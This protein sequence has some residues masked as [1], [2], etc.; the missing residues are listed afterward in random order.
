MADDAQLTARRARLGRAAYLP[1]SFTLLLGGCANL[2]P[3]QGMGPIQ[4]M[5]LSVADA[6]LIKVKSEE[7]AAEVKDRVSALLRKPLTL[8]SAVQIALLNNRGLQAAYNGLGITEAQLAKETL[9]PNPSFSYALLAASNDL[10]IE[11]QVAINVPAIL[12]LP[13]RTDIARLEF[14]AAQFRAMNETLKAAAETRRAFIRAVAANET[15]TFLEKSQLSAEAAS[16]LAKKLGQTGA[17]NKLDQAREHAFYAELSAQ[18][19]SARLRQAA[20]REKLTRLLGLWGSDIGYRLPGQ[21]KPLPGKP[22][23]LETAER[24]AVANRVDLEMLRLELQA[25]AKALGLTEATRFINVL[26]ASAISNPEKETTVQNGVTTTDRFRRSGYDFQFEIPIFDFGEVKVA[27]ARETYLRGVNRLIGKAVTVR[28]EARGAYTAYR[29]AYDIARHYRD[30]VAPLRKVI[31][32]EDLLRYNGMLLDLFQLLADARA[33][34]TS[35][36]AGIEALC[37]FWLASVDLQTALTGG[38][39]SGEAPSS[40]TLA[41][42]SA[43]SE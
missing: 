13:S 18:L 43:G 20:E 6:D 9:P 1:L 36:I 7:D 32:D 24:E 21:L 22:K 11:R 3:D 5:A 15:V 38:G 33:N 23:A 2:S 37:D 39:V 4:S 28:S 27:E 25:Q 40:V 19:G 35:T 10:D 31:A 16:E 34:V 29:G 17:L 12:T 26:Q 42:S 30:N 14:R 41:A 8:E